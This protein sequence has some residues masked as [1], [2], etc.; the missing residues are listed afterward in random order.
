M[1]E[2]RFTYHW[3]IVIACFLMMAATVGI[4]VNTFTII[5]PAMIEDLG[6]TATQAQLISLVST[7]ANMVAGLFVG[8][9]MARF[10]MRKTMTVGT[11]LM[12]GGF[13]LR[14]AASTM[15]T[16]CASNF[17]CGLGMAEISTIPSGVLV[18]NWFSMEKKG[19][20]SGIAF[21]GSVVGG[22]LF[23][24][25]ATAL[26]KVYDWRVTHYVL[27]AVCAVLMLPISMF[28]V[29]ARPEEK[30]LCPLGSE[31]AAGGACPVVTGISAKRFFR[32]GTFWLL[33]A[34]MF[35]IG[36]INMGMQNNFSIYMQ[37]ELG[38]SEGFSTNV[39]TLVMGIQIVGKVVLG[40]V[41]DKKGV[42]FGTA[43]CTVLFLLAAGCSLKAGGTGLAIAFGAFF[44]LVCSMTTVTPPYLTMLVVGRRNYSVIYGLLSLFYGVGV[45]VG[46]VVAAKVFDGS[47][48]YAPA[49]IAFMVLALVMAVATVAGVRRS[50]EYSA[51]AD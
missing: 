20:M 25:V 14:G 28:V 11:I 51:A 23:V 49:W 12:C 29:R 2:K 3:V 18:N 9:L 27:A 48:S 6:I 4:T 21:T 42:K 32:T 26:M 17:V 46:P 13:A 30:G 19:T 7:L 1:K 5:S 44:G 38:H 41:Y 39:F 10:G 35:I 47:G 31:N 24:Q 33:A 8:K 16:L 40:A 36:F 43:Y 22:I 45:A 37:D 34:S 15:L 50:A